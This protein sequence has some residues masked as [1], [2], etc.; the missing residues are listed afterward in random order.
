MWLWFDPAMEFVDALVVE[1][2]GTSQNLNDKR[3]RYGPGAGV[4]LARVSA[5][6]LA[7]I[8]TRG[9]GQARRWEIARVSEPAQEDEP[10]IPVRWLQVLYSLPNELYRT[11]TAG[12]VAA[13]HEFFCR[14]G[15]MGSYNSQVMGE[16]L[17]RM[18]WRAHFLTMPGQ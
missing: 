8:P 2:C 14:H 18:T 9:G 12:R 5:G 6:W 11:W 3:S 4:L 7:A 13:P 10:R 17:S 1:V 16:F 15:S